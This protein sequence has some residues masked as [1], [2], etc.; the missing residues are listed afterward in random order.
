[1]LAS[2]SVSVGMADDLRALPDLRDIS[3]ENKELAALVDELYSGRELRLDGIEEIRNALARDERMLQADQITPD[4]LREARLQL[5]TIESRVKILR[6]RIDQR[7]LSRERLREQLTEVDRLPPVADGDTTATLRLEA[8]HD[9]LAEQ[10]ELTERI[11]AAYAE[12]V[13]L[14]ERHADL[15]SER[16]R[17]LQSRLRPRAL[18]QGLFADDHR[19][20]LLESVIDEHMRRAARFA[21]R[22]SKLP[23]T[24]P[25]VAAERRALNVRIDDA[26]RA[27]CARTT[28]S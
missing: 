19:L 9:L 14:G 18:D 15:L 3:R 21:N 23:T 27:S 6:G 7:R 5:D 17:L 8:A 13:R 24:D 25:G 1:L 22:R 16:L 20:P 4:M 28:W 10:A 2:V 11:I 12:L 26:I